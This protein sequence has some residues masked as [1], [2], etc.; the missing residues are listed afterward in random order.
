MATLVKYWKNT[1]IIILIAVIL[2]MRA[3]QPTTTEIVRPAPI[4]IESKSYTPKIQ[5][6]SNALYIKHIESSIPDTIY[7]TIFIHDDGT[8]DSAAII[9]DWLTIRNYADTLVNND[10]ATLIVFDQ[11]YKNRIQNRRY[12]LLMHPQPVVYS[13]KRTK[14]FAGFGA[15]GWTDAF[16]VHGTLAI[17]TKK[18]HLY[19]ISYDPINK[20]VYLSLYWKISFRKNR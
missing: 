18:D 2:V 12:S 1:V 8:V 15:N 7:D 20:S 13:E 9:K 14:L 5:T 11:V 19:S 17:L 6:E 16:G 10:T 3:C 4:K